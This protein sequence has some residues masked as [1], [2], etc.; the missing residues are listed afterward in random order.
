MSNLSRRYSTLRALK[1]PSP[2]PIWT[3]S[4]SKPTNIS[5]KMAFGALCW[6]ELPTCCKFLT[7]YICSACVVCH[8][9]MCVGVSVPLNTSEPLHSQYA[10]PRSSSSLWIGALYFT[11]WTRTRAWKQSL[12]AETHC[13]STSSICTT[14]CSL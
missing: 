9:T 13:Q 12:C 14:M 3:L 5:Q 11:A 4:S 8:V 7:L 2:Y 10:F 6:L 1:M